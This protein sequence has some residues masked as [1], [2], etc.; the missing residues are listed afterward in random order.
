MEYILGFFLEID[1]RFTFFKKQN[2][3][4]PSGFLYLLPSKISYPVGTKWYDEDEG[5]T[6]YLT[7]CF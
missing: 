4:D 7:T 2:N 6:T 5:L 1:L 3:R